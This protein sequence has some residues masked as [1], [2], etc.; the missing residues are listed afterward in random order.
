MVLAHIGRQALEEGL[1]GAHLCIAC[2]F[3]A[4]N[5]ERLQCRL[6]PVLANEQPVFHESLTQPSAE[7]T[8]LPTHKTYRSD[9]KLETDGAPC[10]GLAMVPIRKVG[11][12]PLLG[13]R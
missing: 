11:A 10:S 12:H 2:N 3:T 13:G 5:Q 9:G 1:K 6:W 8:G 4:A 7:S